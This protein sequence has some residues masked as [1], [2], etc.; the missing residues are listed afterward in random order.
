MILVAAAISLSRRRPGCGS[1]TDTD[2]SARLGAFR[3]LRLLT[4]TPRSELPCAAQTCGHRTAKELTGVP[5]TSLP[6]L[7]TDRRVA[8]WY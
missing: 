3:T 1:S 4:V 7:G 5:I 2:G 8:T 6:V